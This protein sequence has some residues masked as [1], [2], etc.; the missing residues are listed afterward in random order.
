MCCWCKK[1]VYRNRHVCSP[2]WFRTSKPMHSCKPKLNILW[3]TDNIW[4]FSCMSKSNGLNVKFV[5][6]N[7]AWQSWKIFQDRAPIWASTNGGAAVFGNGKDVHCFLFLV[8]WLCLVFAC[9][10]SS[11]GDNGRVVNCL[12][13]P[14][15]LRKQK[16]HGHMGLLSGNNL[17]TP[18]TDIAGT[19]GSVRKWCNNS[20]L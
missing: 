17:Q 5:S 14:A 13:G 1:W 2:R 9:V 6:A 3:G 8:V 18:P 16:K 12:A 20:T 11:M 19:V 10:Y 7:M 15:D 4:Y